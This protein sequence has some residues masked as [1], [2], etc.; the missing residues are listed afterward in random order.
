MVVGNRAAFSGRSLCL[1]GCHTD[2]TRAE[3]IG[4]GQLSAHQGMIAVSG[5]V[6]A[7]PSFA[8]GMAPATGCAQ[9]PVL[10]G[11]RQTADCAAGRQRRLADRSVAAVCS[12][13]AAAAGPALLDRFH[14]PKTP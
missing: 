12:P 6:R 4:S 10:A 1:Y 5:S 9:V 7:V 3:K 11:F 14:S 2:V 13:N 8:A